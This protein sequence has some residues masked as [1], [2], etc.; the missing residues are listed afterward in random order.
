MYVCMYNTVSLKLYLPIIADRT[1]LA[2]SF[3]E[4]CK[5]RSAIKQRHDYAG[6][7]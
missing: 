1:M 2:F 5:S 3:F 4:L 6:V 7:F